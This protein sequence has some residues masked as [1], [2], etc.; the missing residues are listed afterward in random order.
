M[1]GLKSTIALVVV[2]AGL[3]AY[4][5]F[6]VAKM[7]EGGAPAADAK[8]QENVFATVQA[9][10]ID[11]VKVSTAA[12]DATTLKKDGTAWKITQ[13]AELPASESDVS[14]LTS[15]LGQAEIV[16]VIDENPSN[17]NDYGLSNPRVEIDFKAAG[18]KDYRKLFIGDKTP[19]GGDFFAKRNDEKKV[20]LISASQDTS[21]NKTTFDLRDKTL[22]KFERDKVDSIDITAAGKTLTLAKDCG[23]W[24]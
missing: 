23:E 18:D 9:D 12:G 1:R 22:L 2:L 14:Q 21:L 17:L 10:K 8:K 16:R 6:V 15:A 7:P 13:P 4:I 5:Y 19:T 24:K 11:E 20:F 3:G